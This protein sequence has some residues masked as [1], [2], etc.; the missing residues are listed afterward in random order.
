MNWQ[1]RAVAHAAAF[2]VALAQELVTDGAVDQPGTVEKGGRAQM[3]TTNANVATGHARVG[4]QAGHIHGNIMIGSDA[5]R[6]INV[7]DGIAELRN[8]LK[9]AHRDGRLDDATYLA[10][11]TELNAASDC[12][13]EDTARSRSTLVVTL[14]KLRG[15]VADVVELASKVATMVAAAKGLS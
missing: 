3:G 12:L 1:P 6:S 14:K 11:E 7:V 5:G 13:K 10:A 9:Q 8:L 2:A 15:L 4:V